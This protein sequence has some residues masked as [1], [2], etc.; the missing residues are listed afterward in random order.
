[1]TDAQATDATATKAAIAD[2]LARHST[3]T[4]ATLGPAGEPMAASLFYSS[5]P[6]LHL[7]WTSGTSSRHSRNLTRS[8]RVAVTIHGETWRWTEIAGV[9]ME[10][11]AVVVPAGQPWVEAWERYRAKFPFVDEFQAEVTRSN[12]YELT[13]RW[14]RLIDN[15]QGFGHKAE[16]RL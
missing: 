14:V 13:P 4:L 12:F 1:M 15:G 6:A 2:F 5:D 10:G 16:L 3:L 11:E 7:Y 9:Q 8:P